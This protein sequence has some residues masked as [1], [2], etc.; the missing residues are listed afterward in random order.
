MIGGQGNIMSESKIYLHT[1][2]V[3]RA[4]QHII[5]HPGQ[6]QWFVTDWGMKQPG[7]EIAAERLTETT[8]RHNGT[9]YDWPLH[10]AESK[11]CDLNA[12]IAAWASP[13]AIHAGKYKP[14]LDPALLKRSILEATRMRH[15]LKREH[16]KSEGSVMTAHGYEGVL[17]ADPDQQAR[18]LSLFIADMPRSGRAAQACRRPAHWARVKTLLCP[19]NF[20]S[21]RNQGGN[22]GQNKRYCHSETARSHQRHSRW[23][24]LACFRKRGGR[25][26]RHSRFMSANRPLRTQRIIRLRRRR[27]SRISI[28]V[29][30]T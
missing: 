18:A 28:F 13:L 19:S 5:P 3:E 15:S 30:G 29:I 4:D 22:A 12:F 21:A 11:D 27:I 1:G 17:S 16:E 20:C 24:I 7:Y 25:R 14:I 8:E 9:F 2:P 26:I 10:T 23:A 6:E